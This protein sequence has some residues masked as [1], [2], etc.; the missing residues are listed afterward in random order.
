MEKSRKE[1]DRRLGE[2]AG[3]WG[4]FVAGMVKP[5]IIELFKDKGIE[6]RTT[7]Q[8]VVGLVG[9]ER[10]YE[11]DLLTNCQSPARHN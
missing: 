8:N 4:K 5:K 6:I 9:D 1:F 7:L 10:Y 3:T 11:I 2:L